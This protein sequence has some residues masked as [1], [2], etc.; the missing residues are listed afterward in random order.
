MEK[1]ESLED[2]I[3]HEL[4]DMYH[5]EQQLVKA[6]PKVAEKASSP[7]LRSSLEE[8]LRETEGH[9]D[10]LEKIFDLLGQPAKAVKCKAMKG[11]LDEGEDLMDLKGSPETIDAGI[12]MAAQKVEHYEIAG[13]GS[14][15]CWA[16]HLGEA[17]AAELL[18]QTLEEEKETDDKLTE[19]A[20]NSINAEQ[21]EEEHAHNRRR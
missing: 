13:Y 2:L 5:A 11:I 1:L 3:L 4:K 9:V 15:K 16:D 10:R 17:E 20:E 19:L 18:E 21:N 7:Q 14:L 8:H 6:L 12:I